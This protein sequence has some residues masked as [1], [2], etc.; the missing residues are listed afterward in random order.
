MQPR[1]FS[2]VSS[3]ITRGLWPC[4]DSDMG[5]SCIRLGSMCLVFGVLGRGP[6][7]PKKRAGNGPT[8]L[9]KQGSGRQPRRAASWDA[10]HTDQYVSNHKGSR[11]AGSR[12]ETPVFSYL[13]LLAVDYA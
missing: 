7:G 10:Q 12:P 13:L 2:T 6:V 5:S 8:A 3:A 9:E 11:N 4:L 1:I